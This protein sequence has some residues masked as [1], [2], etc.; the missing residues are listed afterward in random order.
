MTLAD[1][2]FTAATTGTAGSTLTTTGAEY[3]V[4]THGTIGIGII[5]LLFI[6]AHYLDRKYSYPLSPKSKLKE[7]E[8]V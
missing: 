2:T 1:L 3:T 5:L 8:E 7:E 6:I 4:Q